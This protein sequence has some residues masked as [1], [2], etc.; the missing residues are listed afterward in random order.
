MLKS[1][2]RKSRKSQRRKSRKR[3]SRKR[4]SQPRKSRKRKS[5]KSQRRKFQYRDRFRKSEIDI[6]QMESAHD[7]MKAEMEA[8]AHD[9]KIID[10]MPPEDL[11]II[12]ELTKGKDKHIL[13]GI[14]QL[15]KKLDLKTD[16]D[17][18]E[19]FDIDNKC[20]YKYLR[21]IISYF[22]KED[23]KMQNSKPCK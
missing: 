17:I 23:F 3:K 8:A 9:K 5:H 10:N 4:K 20:N 16:L 13:R 7:E 12:K 18:I 6:K 21:K 2:K 11:Q 15:Y 19:N 1:R 14:L 22:F